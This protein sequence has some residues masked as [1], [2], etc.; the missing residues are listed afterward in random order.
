MVAKLEFFMIL[1][2]NWKLLITAIVSE[3]GNVGLQ[4][5]R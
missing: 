3:S 4:S 2:K 5:V 1:V